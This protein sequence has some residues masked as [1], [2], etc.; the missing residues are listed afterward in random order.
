MKELAYKQSDI[1][2]FNE[3][4]DITETENFGYM[5]VIGGDLIIDTCITPYDVDKYI[6][7]LQKYKKLFKEES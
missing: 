5:E 7:I 4:I 2:E 3:A 6:D 1:D